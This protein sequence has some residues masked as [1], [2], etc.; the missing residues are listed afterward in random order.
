MS[1]HIFI[2]YS[3]QDSKVVGEFVEALRKAD[4]IVW[5]DVSGISAGDV[6]EQTLYDAID[7]AA[8]VVVFWSQSAS[9]SEWVGKEIAHA[10]KQNKPI[11]PIWLER[12]TPLSAE[13]AKYNAI[14]SR[15]F[16]PKLTDALLA[17]APRIQ[18]RVA[19][20]DASIP[21]SKQKHIGREAIG[22]T[23]YVTLT[24]VESA[25]CKAVL[26]AEAST[27]IGQV[28]RVQLIIQNTRDVG[29][30]SV[31]DTFAT[32]LAEDAQHPEHAQPIVGLHVT[33][34]VNPA[35]TSK[36]YIDATNVAHYS[37]MSDTTHKAISIL[38]KDD[39]DKVFQ[40]FLFTL[41]DIAFLVAI[42]A[43]RWITFQLYKWLGN[44]Y[45]RIMTIP[46]RLP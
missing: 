31:K 45:S 28:S 17:I 36:Y 2:S 38:T 46:P 16:T 4:F 20:F 30:A 24:L 29:Y 41:V 18:R 27:I 40:V 12:A 5:Q 13:L 26:I 43:N 21:M 22:K 11:I 3:R 23:E 9:L 19:E 7:N 25:Y 32:I 1:S 37:D 35:D 6:W 15:T 14:P 33:G 34:P 44:T 42:S 39:R 10:I 8:V